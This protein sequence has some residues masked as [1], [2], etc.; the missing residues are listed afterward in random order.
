VRKRLCAV[1][2]YSGDQSSLEP[3]DRLGHDP[4]GDVTAEALRAK[5]AI[6]LRFGAQA[7]PAAP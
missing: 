6:R 4:D 3:L 7:P 2:M 1:L 5:R